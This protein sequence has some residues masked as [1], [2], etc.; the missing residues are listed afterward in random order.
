VEP[1]VTAVERETAQQLL[2]DG[3]TPVKVASA[4][5]R[6]RDRRGSTRRERLERRAEKRAEWAE[7]RAAKAERAHAGVSRIADG[8]PFGQPILVGHHSEGRARADQ[9]RMHRGMDAAVEHSQMASRHEQAADGIERALR[10]SV[11]SD[12]ADAVER[13]TEI[14]AALEAKRDGMKAANAAY[15]AEH[16]AELKV[17]G[18]Y[19]RSQAVPYP[20]CSITNLGA[21]IRQK[22]QRI[23][24]IKRDHALAA[25]GVRV[26]GR[27]MESRYGGECP[28][29]GQPF[30]RGAQIV[31]YRATREAIHAA[32]P[33]AED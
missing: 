13:L 6:A 22:T 25:R 30:E 1:D 17:M 8:I 5:L 16:R 3:W 33:E 10:T 31:W 9:A 15:R 21:T 4:L 12:D 27:R 28:D 19:E 26:G 29:C 18:A 24:Q 2:S 7:S 20:S 14:V 32:C 11:Y 23:E